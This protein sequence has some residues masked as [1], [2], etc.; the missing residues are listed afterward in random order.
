MAEPPMTNEELRRLLA[1]AVADLDSAVDKL[2]RAGWH[3]VP[4]PHVSEGLHEAKLRISEARGF[5]GRAEHV[6]GQWA[7]KHKTEG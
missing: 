7:E 3:G 6:Q 5:V 2:E 1:D 4:A